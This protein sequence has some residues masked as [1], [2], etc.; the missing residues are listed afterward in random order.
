MG[1]HVRVRTMN[2]GEMLEAD[3]MSVNIFSF[4]IAPPASGKSQAFNPTVAKPMEAISQ[5]LPSP[6][7]FR[8]STLLKSMTYYTFKG[9]C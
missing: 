4:A 8:V 9:M 6:M 5:D 1:P 7:I 3:L 2:F